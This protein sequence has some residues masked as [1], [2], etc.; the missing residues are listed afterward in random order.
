MT[1]RLRRRRDPTGKSIA[2]LRRETFPTL[3]AFVRGYLHEDFPEVHGSL[4]G[5]AAAF[6]QDASPGERRQLA[7]ELES[8]LHAVAD[9]PAH[10]LRRFVTAEL[11][12]RWEP[13]S[14][15]E[16]AELLEFF[17]KAS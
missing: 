5:A 7:Q 4:R 14:R 6:S 2:A 12:S 1:K 10:E 8:L 3:T 17:R 13:G 16:L 9:Q 15:E 11:G